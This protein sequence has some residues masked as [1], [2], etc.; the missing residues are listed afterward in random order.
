MQVL[1]GLASTNM[2]MLFLSNNEG[3]LCKELISAM[4]AWKERIPQSGPHQQGPPRWTVA[5]TVANLLMTD[6]NHRARLGEFVE[7]HGALKTIK[8]MEGS[9]QLTVAKKTRDGKVL[10]KICLHITR[11]AE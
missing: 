10:L 7:N 5:G 2:D 6:S 1:T 9:A 11:Q 3:K 8:E 4:A